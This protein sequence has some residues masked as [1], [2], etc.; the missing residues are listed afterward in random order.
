MNVY[1]KKMIIIFQNSLA[2]VFHL[3]FYYSVI[4]EIRKRH[5]LCSMKDCEICEY[6][7]FEPWINKRGRE[8]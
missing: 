8:K 1:I 7:I 3:Y 4:S 5:E 6:C 2:F